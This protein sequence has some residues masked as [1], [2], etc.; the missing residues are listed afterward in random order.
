LRLRRLELVLRA[1]R[2]I[3]PVSVTHLGAAARSFDR[4]WGPS[5]RFEPTS[6]QR[7]LGAGSDTDRVCRRGLRGASRCQRPRSLR[8]HRS[9]HLRR[10][11]RQFPGQSTLEHEI[12]RVRR[13]DFIFALS[14]A[15][16]GL[17]FREVSPWARP[18]AVRER[19]S[20]WCIICDCSTLLALCRTALPSTGWRRLAPSAFL[21]ER[22]SHVGSWDIGRRH[23]PGQWRAATVHAGRTDRTR[24]SI[25]WSP[26][27]LQARA[28]R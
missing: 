11:E 5:E 16:A 27:Q 7:A 2:Q 19:L 10:P 15:L 23:L 18:L 13:F 4:A 20:H 21:A 3:L 26:L 22:G 17:R 6:R 8:R 14:L 25:L 12:P 28:K 1:P 24:P 9:R